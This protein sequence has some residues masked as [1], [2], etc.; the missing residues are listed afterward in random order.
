MHSEPFYPCGMGKPV[1]NAHD[2]PAFK[3][4]IIFFFFYLS[5]SLWFKYRWICFKIRIEVEMRKNFHRQDTWKHC[6]P[7]CE[8]DWQDKGQKSKL[9]GEKKRKQPCGSLKGAV[10][11]DKETL[12]AAV[13]PICAMSRMH[14]YFLS[15]QRD[16]VKKPLWHLTFLLVSLFIA[17]QCDS[18][19]FFLK[20]ESCEKKIQ[21]LGSHIERWHSHPCDCLEKGWGYVCFV[22]IT[23]SS[24]APSHIQDSSLMI[25]VLLPW[26][27]LPRSLI[28]TR[29]IGKDWCLGFSSGGFVLQH[30]GASSVHA[31]SELCQGQ[32]KHCGRWQISIKEAYIGSL[33]VKAFELY[34][35]LWCI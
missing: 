6:A 17:K 16:N 5:H 29:H 11:S 34:T 24:S 25:A 10:P 20:V 18:L 2:S 13:S 35:V 23:A 19:G 32:M 4:K 12:E 1:P 15:E 31:L 9:C 21:A 27:L 28:W 30:S 8:L 7:E 14:S 26:P 3:C 33:P 22:V